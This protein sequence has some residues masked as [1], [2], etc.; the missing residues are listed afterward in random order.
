MLMLNFLS[1]LIDLDIQLLP[2]K[3]SIVIWNG[4]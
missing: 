3:F 4:C 2:G 1:D